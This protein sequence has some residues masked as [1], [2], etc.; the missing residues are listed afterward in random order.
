MNFAHSRSWI[1]RERPP[2]ALTPVQMD[3]RPRPPVAQPPLAHDYQSNLRV[4]AE[5]RRV[6]DQLMISGEGLREPNN[7]ASI[8]R[9]EPD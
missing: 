4:G 2:T 7:G 8:A 9:Y 5:L 6:N 1:C 3:L